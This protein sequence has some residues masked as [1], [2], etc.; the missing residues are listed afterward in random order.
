MHL[1]K[2]TTLE[3]KAIVLSYATKA[4]VKHGIDGFFVTDILDH[5]QI[6][7]RE[8]NLLF[9]SEMQLIDNIFRHFF[10]KFGNEVTKIANEPGTKNIRLTKY[11]LSLKIFFTDDDNLDLTLY[12]ANA[13]PSVYKQNGLGI[14]HLFFF[15]RFRKSLSSLL[16]EFISND[17]AWQTCREYA[18]GFC[19]AAKRN[20]II[21]KKFIADLCDDVLNIISLPPTC[22]NKIIYTTCLSDNSRKMHTSF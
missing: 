8:F 10:K 16:S 4:L 9:N 19:N 18:Q 5:A 21:L 12:L 1:L 6:N 14:D 3:K 20:R 2:Q 22:I 7:R 13:G 17:L 11:L 15:D